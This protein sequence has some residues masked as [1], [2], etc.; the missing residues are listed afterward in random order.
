MIYKDLWEAQGGETSKTIW[1]KVSMA[2]AGIF[3][4]A[5]ALGGGQIAGRISGRPR[6]PVWKNP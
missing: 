4:A 2:V 6:R 1:E 3:L 5:L